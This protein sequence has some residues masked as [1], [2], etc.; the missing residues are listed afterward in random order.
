MHDL[1][2]VNHIISL[3][4]CVCFIRA[5]SFQ[6]LVPNCWGAAAPR[7][8]VEQDQIFAAIYEHAKEKASARRARAEARAAARVGKQSP[9]SS[10]WGDRFADA[11]G[12]AG[13]VN[14]EI[15]GALGTDAAY[16]WRDSY[17]RGTV[18]WCRLH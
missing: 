1:E 18:G 6:I 14:G 12:K 13:D 4:F 5:N 10:S 15:H 3:Q 17:G 11:H 9:S 16:C 2:L 8:Q 7:T